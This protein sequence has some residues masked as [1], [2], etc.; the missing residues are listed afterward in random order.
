MCTHASTV[1]NSA[2]GKAKHPTAFVCAVLLYTNECRRNYC[3]PQGQTVLIIVYVPLARSTGTPDGDSR[4]YLLPYKKTRCHSALVADTM[5]VDVYGRWPLVEM[6]RNDRMRSP[7]KTNR[8]L[9]DD[10]VSTILRIDVAIKE[11]CAKKSVQYSL[12][13]V[14]QLTPPHCRPLAKKVWDA[15]TRPGEVAEEKVQASQ[16]LSSLISYQRKRV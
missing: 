8:Y 7:C 1:E 5:V 9:L 4:P 14:P 16:N 12:L 11:A 13:A 10:M 15:F 2:S 3:V 6:E